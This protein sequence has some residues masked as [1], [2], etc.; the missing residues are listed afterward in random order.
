M[1]NALRTNAQ[2][3]SETMDVLTTTTLNRQS[4]KAAGLR[5]WT[6]SRARSGLFLGLFMWCHMAFVSTILISNEAMWWVTKMFE[7]RFILGKSYPVMSAALLPPL[8]LCSWPTVFLR[9]VSCPA[10]FQQLRIF[11][12]D[13]KV[14]RHE[15]T[16]LWWLQAITG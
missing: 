11:R 14:L 16:S 9:C 2:S 7:G 6:S 4:R 13:R 5:D 15:D 10:N 1:Q 12:D 8:P 3:M